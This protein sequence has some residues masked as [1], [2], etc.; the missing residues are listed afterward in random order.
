MKAEAWPRAGVWKT[1]AVLSQLLLG[2]RA[3]SKPHRKPLGVAAREGGVARAGGEGGAAGSVLGTSGETSLGCEA[4]LA[5]PLRLA[6]SGVAR[7]G[8]ALRGIVVEP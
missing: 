5:R 8:V 7:G 6:A 3:E 1:V 2:P 4:P